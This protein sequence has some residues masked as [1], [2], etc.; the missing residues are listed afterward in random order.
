VSHV[1]E[2]ARAPTE[3]N[4]VHVKPPCQLHLDNMNPLCR[5]AIV[6]RG[7]P[8][9]VRIVVGDREV[10]FASVRIHEVDETRV[11]ARA[12]EGA[13]NDV[14]ASV[15]TVGVGRASEAGHGV[16]GKN[17]GA[18]K[19]RPLLLDEFY[20]SSMIRAVHLA[21]TLFERLA[22]EWGGKC[23]VPLARIAPNDATRRMHLRPPDY[24]LSVDIVL[25]SVQVDDVARCPCDEQSSAFE[26]RRP[27]ELVDVKIRIF[28]NGA[29][30]SEKIRQKARRNV[31]SRMR[32]LDD[33]RGLCRL[34]RLGRLGSADGK[35]PVGH[36]LSTLASPQA[37]GVG[38]RARASSDVSS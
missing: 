29:R 30:R 9:L 24:R 7:E 36:A 34:G 23:T 26:M 38:G 25:R 1:F 31:E 4:F 19:A 27:I 11:R 12:P 37:T 33:E 14:G 10:G 3:G 17:D 35:Q 2:P 8:P 28:S 20:E 32:D 18:A 6:L 21:K 5:A 13:R 15:R 22:P 16:G